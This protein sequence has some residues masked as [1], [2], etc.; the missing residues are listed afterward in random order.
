MQTVLIVIHLMIVLAL[1][2]V[3]LLQ[4]S[5]G[6]ALGIGGG[7]GFMAGRSA[8]N[9]LSR[10][11]AYLAAGFFA[12]SIALTIIAGYGGGSA[13][14]RLQPSAAQP[15]PATAPSGPQAP[16]GTGQGGILPALKPAGGAGS[17]PQP[18]FAP[19]SSGE[20]T[21]PMGGAAAPSAPAPAA[22]AAPVPGGDVNSPPTDGDRQVPG[23]AQT[24]PMPQDATP[25]APQVSD[26]NAPRPRRRSSRPPPSRPRRTPARRPAPRPTPL[27]PRPPAPSKRKPQFNGKGPERSGPFLFARGDGCPMVPLQAPSRPYAMIV[28][29]L[30]FSPVADAISAVE[31][32]EQRKPGEGALLR[33]L[34]ARLQDF[35]LGVELATKRGWSRW[36]RAMAAV[37]QSGRGTLQSR[38]LALRAGLTAARGETRP[39]RPLFA[40]RVLWRISARSREGLKLSN[41]KSGGTFGPAALRASS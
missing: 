33:C 1:V 4:K 19:P 36:S 30:R 32:S 41:R 22:P 8:S 28:L 17:P 11:T 15:R 3:V 2:V 13:F 40:G 39:A 18:E 20:P 14:D 21:P 29:V 38:M 12:T 7:G 6:G 9:P 16:L 5:E 23:G 25:V 26:P 35:S 34:P 27:R 31:G 37:V 10:L 24:A